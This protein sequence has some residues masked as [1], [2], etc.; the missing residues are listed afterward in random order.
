[1][2]NERWAM[3]RILRAG[4]GAG[5]WQSLKEFP[6]L[7]E[8]G[9]KNP[10]WGVGRWGKERLRFVPDDD[11][12]FALRGDK[13]RLVYKGKKRSHRFT[14]LTDTSFEYDCILL[15]EP[16]TN[17]VSLRMEGA[18][19]F[20]FFR[21]PDYVSDP[22]LKGSYAVYK[23]K[24]L[25]GEGTGKLCHIYRPEITDARGRRCWGDLSAGNGSLKIAVPEKWLGEASYPVVVDPVIGT[26]VVGSQ[27][28]WRNDDWEYA[29][30]FLEASMSANM[31]VMTHPFISGEAVARVYAYHN[32]H[33]DPCKPFAYSDYGDIPGV[34][35][36]SNSDDFDIEVR[37]GKR[38][39]WRSAKFNIDTDIEL[40]ENIWFG[41]YSNY[42][43][44]MFDYGDRCYVEHLDNWGVELPYHYP[45]WSARHSR[46]FKLSMF[47]EFSY[48][49]NFVRVLT[50]GV[51]LGDTCKYKT[52][53]NRRISDI[54][55]A[56]AARANRSEFFRKNTDVVN[57]NSAINGLHTLIRRIAAFI[58]PR[59]K[60]GERRNIVSLCIDK[61]GARSGIIRMLD[62]VCRIKDYL[63]GFDAVS[64]TVLFIRKIMSNSEAGD[65]TAG[66]GGF[67]LRLSDTSS[68][69]S[70]I[71]RKAGFVCRY[72]ETVKAESKLVRK[73]LLL[74]KIIANFICNDNI[75]SKIMKTPREVVI[76]SRITREL[77]IS[78]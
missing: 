78:N 37:G 76:K 72:A 8:L 35:I 71:E 45:I 4:R 28:H 15:K 77:I 33:D 70:G 55:E 54:A 40:G 68:N 48:P 39:G 6:C 31:F 52:N 67:N 64:D 65:K 23:K 57:N 43:A 58:I 2:S 20:D 62:A 22:L 14:V 27:T 75:F 5:F 61:A 38:E 59:T 18:E 24:T 63:N 16:D 44:P 12:G 41:I 47:F 26:S 13:R 19:N 10:S 49:Q 1:M 42:F 11:E 25:L 50:Q 66:F 73:L 69:T 7:V 32:E 34:K 21:Q 9:D 51:S 46:N 60:T 74:I 29:R 3:G 17:I 56:M 53:F 30:L 36:S